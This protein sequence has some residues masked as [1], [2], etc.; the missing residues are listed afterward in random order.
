MMLPLLVEDSIERE[1]RGINLHP[2]NLHFATLRIHLVSKGILES[3]AEN[4]E[5]ETTRT[6]QKLKW[7]AKDS[8]TLDVLVSFFSADNELAN[9]H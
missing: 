8:E 4:R 6:T 5:F 7:T 9:H 3:G 2:Q 1:R